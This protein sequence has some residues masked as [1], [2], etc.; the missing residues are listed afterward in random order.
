M[1]APDATRLLRAYEQYDSAP[2]F[3]ADRLFQAVAAATIAVFCALGLYF[4]TIRPIRENIEQRAQRMQAQFILAEKK[5]PPPKPKPAPKAA[6]KPVDL[7]ESPALRQKEEAVA[8]EPKTEE[9]PQPRRVYGLRR[10]YA[11]GIGSGG[12]LSEAV[13]GKLGNTLNKD[14]DTLT[15]KKEELKGPLASVT[16]IT[17]QPVIKVRIKPE[18]TREMI[19]N[20]VEGVIRAKILVDID[21]RVKDVQLQNDL[22]YGSAERARESFYK[23]VFEPAMRDNVAVAVWITVSFRFVLQQT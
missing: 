21:G 6:E 3:S 12:A 10:V 22:G 20:R 17:K 1:T 23:L 9:K 7:S 16:T 13:I 2:S 4:T 18:Y 8:P 14:V 11:K 19:D 15:A 5:A